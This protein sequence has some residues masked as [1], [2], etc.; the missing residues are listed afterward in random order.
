MAAGGGLFCLVRRPRSYQRRLI[1][2]DM[3]DCEVV[4]RF[5]LSRARI[6]WLANELGDELRRNT[7]RS[8]RGVTTLTNAVWAI[9][10]LNLSRPGNLDHPP[11]FWGYIPGCPD[12]FLHCPGII[13]CF[14][15]KYP[16]VPI[17]GEISRFP[18]QFWLCPE[19]AF[20]RVV[21][22]RRSFPLAPEIQ[23]NTSVV[24]VVVVVFK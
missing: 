2:A 20:V 1:L 4:E 22:P 15:E 5:R 6:E 21:T 3:A 7:A 13:A 23:I 24:I 11:E 16:S 12:F 18:E 14:P 9:L 10:G 19:T 17:P 8:L